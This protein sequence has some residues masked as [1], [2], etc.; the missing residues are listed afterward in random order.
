M[1][2]NTLL[3]TALVGLVALVAIVAGVAFTGDSEPD[4]ALYVDRAEYEELEDRPQQLLYEKTPIKAYLQ[5]CRNK[6]SEVIAAETADT[7]SA[8]SSF[9]WLQFS[10]AE[11]HVYTLR[12]LFHHAAQLSMRLRINADMDIPWTKSAWR[13][14]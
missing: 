14:L 2:N 12:H 9:D 4:P 5:H 13:D 6:A 11:L 8:R 10:R 1:T 3:I 7:L